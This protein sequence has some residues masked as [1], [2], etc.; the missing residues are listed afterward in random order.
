V[1]PRKQEKWFSGHKP[2][3]GLGEE[4][5]SRASGF[6]WEIGS[7]VT[8]ATLDARDCVSPG[9]KPELPEKYGPT[10]DLR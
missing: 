6:G 7:I 1:Y 2:N 9:I 4:I 10:P 3:Y 8:P 5:I